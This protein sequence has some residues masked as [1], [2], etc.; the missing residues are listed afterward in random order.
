MYAVIVSV[1]LKGLVSESAIQTP[2]NAPVLIAFFR[3]N[4]AVRRSS[5]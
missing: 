2:V 4:A 1:R 3:R 5:L